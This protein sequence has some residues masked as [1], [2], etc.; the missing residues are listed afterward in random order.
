VI[1]S[2]DFENRRI[3]LGHKQVQD[4]PW[5]KYAVEYAVGNEVEA[6]VTRSTDKGVF[7]R[8]PLGVEAYMPARE[9]EKR[10]NAESRGETYT[11]NR[12][13]RDIGLLF[14]WYA[15]EMP[16]RWH[17]DGKHLAMMLEAWDN[18]DRWIVTM[19]VTTDNAL[20]TQHRKHD[21]AWIN[22]RFN[23]FGWLEDSLSLYLL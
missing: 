17:D 16:I 1:L 19:D 9:A 13:P 8:L 23:Q 15:T 6:E 2:V 20:T 4:N 22:Y 10:E 11:A 18:K 3:S 21:D 12:L 5:E 7:L 14:D